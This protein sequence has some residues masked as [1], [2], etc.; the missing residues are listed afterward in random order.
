MEK[1]IRLPSVRMLTALV[2]LVI[3]SVVMSGYVTR[4]FSQMMSN[5]TNQTNQS[6]SMGANITGANANNTNASAPHAANM[7]TEKVLAP[8]GTVPS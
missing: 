7:T 2:V 6:R 4:T 8:N 1:S 5:S 3:F